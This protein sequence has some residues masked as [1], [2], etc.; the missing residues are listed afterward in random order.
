M[1]VHPNKYRK[2]NPALIRQIIGKG[3]AAAS[4]TLVAWW[5]M[6]EGSGNYLYDYSGNSYTLFNSS[7]NNDWSTL[8]GF[9]VPA[10]LWNPGGRNCSVLAGYVAAL[11]F[12]TSTAWSAMG[13]VNYSQGG[14]VVNNLNS[15]TNYSGWTLYASYYPTQ[16]E[17]SAQINAA[18]GSSITVS[19]NTGGSFALN[20][21]YHVAATYD[22]S[23][24]GAGVKLYINGA[25][26]PVTITSD[27]LDEAAS[28][29]EPVTLAT[30]ASDQYA[31]AEGY[32]ADTRIYTGVLTPAQIFTIH[33][34]GPS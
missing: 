21:T 1:I 17:I 11:N 16:N 33:A 28:S 22:G 23:G 5:K 12:G 10:V 2:L 27:T 6:N 14:P 31:G 3:V 9:A 15:N 29:T 4:T 8:P 18:D 34:T 30:V 20:T 24:H 7:G 26:V 13:W 25:S 32:Q 19:S